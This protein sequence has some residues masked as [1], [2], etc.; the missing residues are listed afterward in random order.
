MVTFRFIPEKRMAV[1]E[2]NGENIAK[3]TYLDRGSYWEITHTYVNPDYR[4]QKI[5]ERIVNMVI[6]EARKAGKKIKPTCSYA[7]RHMSNK[8]EYEDILVEE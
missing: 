4:G 1:A 2:D 8:P 7:V 3:C 5:A 6:D